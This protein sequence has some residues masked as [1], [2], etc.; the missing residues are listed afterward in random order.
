MFI[1]LC[2]INL[3]L[4][5]FSDAVTLEIQNTPITVAEGLR[6]AV[7]GGPA[8]LIFWLTWDHDHLVFTH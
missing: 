5:P 2:H 3:G 8:T 4:G 7:D 6:F 1:A